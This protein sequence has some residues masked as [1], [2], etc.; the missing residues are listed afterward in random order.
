MEAGEYGLT[1]GTR[2]VARCLEMVAVAAWCG[3][4]GV[5][6]VG[7]DFFVFFFRLFFFFERTRP[8]ASMRPPY[9]IYLSTSDL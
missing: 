1:R 7:R 5:F 6:S 2:F 8:A 3:F 9:L 4:R